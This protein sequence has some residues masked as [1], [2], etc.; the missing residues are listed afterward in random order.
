MSKR[1]E[2]KR[3]VEL[4]KLN[5]E[6]EVESVVVSD[7]IEEEE[8]EGEEGEIESFKLMKEVLDPDLTEVNEEAVFSK[9]LDLKCGWADEY[10][11]SQGKKKKTKKKAVDIYINDHSHY[12]KKISSL[13]NVQEKYPLL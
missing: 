5:P 8:E 3:N 13:G 1:L 11:D 4:N 9:F 6:A 2:L 7:L 10:L 12:L